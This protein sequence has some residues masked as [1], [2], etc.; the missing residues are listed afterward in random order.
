MRVIPT[1]I[2]EVLI[3]DLEHFEDAR[4]SFVRH[5]DA[6][7]WEAA[8]IGPFVQDNLSR[9]AENVLRGL[10]FQRVRPQGKLLS[11][12]AGAIFDV[13]VDIRPDSP[14]FGAWVGVHLNASDNRQ[15]WV[16]PGFAHGFCVT[17]GPVVVHYRCTTAY[18]EADQGGLKWDDPALGISWPVSQPILSDRDRSLPGIDAIRSI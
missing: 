8:G 6:Q 2:P 9:S 5:W 10:H 16:P 1:Q 4:G 13:A 17:E 18:V 11:V 12:M 15:L 7:L 14:T 3:L